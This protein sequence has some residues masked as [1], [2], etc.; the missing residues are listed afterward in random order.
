MT[1]PPLF[2]DHDGGHPTRAALIAL[3]DVPDDCIE[4]A[5]TALLL[6][7]LDHPGTSL[8][9]YR[10]HLATMCHSLGCRLDGYRSTGKLDD[11]SASERADLLVEVMVDEWDYHGDVN[12]YDDPQNVDLMRVID[13]RKGLPVALGILYL[14]VARAQGW[15]ADGLNFPGHF[16]IRLEGTDGDRVILDPFHD[17]QRLSVA[18]LRALLKLVSGQDAELAPDTYA[19]LSARGV[20]TRLQGNVKLRMLE[21]GHLESAL[22]A[23]QR[24]ILI[25][26]DDY[27]L[28]REAG[29]MQ[30]R[31][32][33][34]ETALE[35]LDSYLML[36]PPGKDR[37]RI[38]QVMS[39]LRQRLH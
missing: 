9:N 17:G 13:R 31:L 24:M 11:L 38:E 1:P 35:T 19:P 5:E 18:D 25:A 2:S 4:V 30:M 20:L 14:H 36:A 22:E 28:W 6:A 12:T 15:A 33:D 37:S 21:G 26:P 23:V 34:L 27:R 10:D 32:G 16:L 7:A 39:E 29:L 3:A 8:D